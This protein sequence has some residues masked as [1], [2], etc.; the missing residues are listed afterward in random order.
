ME[1][2]V[3]VAP[4]AGLLC[5]RVVSSGASSGILVFVPIGAEVGAAAASSALNSEGAGDCLFP[6]GPTF[7]SSFEGAG[8][9]GGT[10]SVLWSGVG[11]EGRVGAGVESAV[12]PFFSFLVF[13]FRT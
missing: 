3:M 8:G 6:V 4:D 7:L 13:F 5:S 2:A 11:D 10:F 9:T 1:W 12:M